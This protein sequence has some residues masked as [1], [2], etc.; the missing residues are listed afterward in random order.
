LAKDELIERWSAAIAR[1]KRDVREALAGERPR[2]VLITGVGSV[3]ADDVRSQLR[4]AEA[5]YDLDV[6]RVSMHEPREVARA[7]SQAAAGAAAVALTRGGGQSVHDLDNDEL[8]GAVASS[9]VPV[10]VALGHASDDLVVARVADTSFPTPTALGS[11]L[12]QTAEARRL[13][14]RQAEEARLLAQSQ[15]LLG[16]LGELGRVRAALAWWRAAA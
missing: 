2:V 7:L 5:D 10:L 15:E 6:V 16:Q 8:I 13:R 3:A 14:A 11:F 4:E 9:A 1:P 12:R